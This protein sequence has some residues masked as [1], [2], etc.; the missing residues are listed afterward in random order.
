M[1]TFKVGKSVMDDPTCIYSDMSYSI[2]LNAENLSPYQNATGH[3]QQN[4][5]GSDIGLSFVCV[6]FLGYKGSVT[7]TVSLSPLECPNVHNAHIFIS[8]QLG[9]G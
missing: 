9:Q 2:E 6:P 4:L 7:V 3:D 1:H 8:V 5:S